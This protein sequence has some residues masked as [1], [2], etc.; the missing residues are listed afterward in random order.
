MEIVNKI[1][2]Y[3]LDK[4]LNKSYKYFTCNKPFVNFANS[5]IFTL[6]R[7][8]FCMNVVKYCLYHP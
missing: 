6:I 2:I 7:N 5:R 1:N 3:Q 8:N 4:R